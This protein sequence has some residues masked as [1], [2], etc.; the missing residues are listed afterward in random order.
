[1]GRFFS[2]WPTWERLVFVRWRRTRTK[3]LVCRPSLTDVLLDFGMCDCRHSPVGKRK[4]R[5]H[6]LEATQVYGCGRKG[7]ER[8]GSP[9]ADEPATTNS[10]K[11]RCGYTFRHK[12]DRERHRGRRRL[13]IAQQYARACE[14]GTIGFV[15]CLG[16]RA[17]KRV[18]PREDGD[19]TASR[20]VGLQLH[21]RDGASR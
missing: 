5:V 13:D 18:R 16:P 7:K 20:A 15:V 10:N 6:A 17:S 12:S 4:T 1:M 11:R 21:N 3:V 8:A 2:S 14:S 19:A 9:A